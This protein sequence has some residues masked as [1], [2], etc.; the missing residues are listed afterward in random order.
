M[1]RHRKVL[2]IDLGRARRGMVEARWRLSELEGR[3]FRPWW[4]RHFRMAQ[5]MG[6]GLRM[7]ERAAY[8]ERVL[9]F[10]CGPPALC[11]WRVFEA[12]AKP[13]TLKERARRIEA[14][15][16]VPASETPATTRAE[17][18]DTVAKQPEKAAR[19]G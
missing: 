7:R 13:W 14:G 6:A 17:T 19:G 16:F 4:L 10:C 2:G 18:V 3:L 15:T 12:K 5:D 11:P 1:A 9:G 8:G